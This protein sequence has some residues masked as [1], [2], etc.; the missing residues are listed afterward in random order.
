MISVFENLFIFY[1]FLVVGFFF[2]R[3][4]KGLQKQTGILSF[5]LC[6]L[7]LPCKLF[8]NFSKNFT[9]EYIASGYKLVLAG[10]VLIIV[11]HFLSKLITRFI[12]KDSY[13]KKVYEYSLTIS[14]Y[15]YLGYALVEG[16]F[17]ETMLTNMIA[18]C[19]FYAAYSYTVGYTKLTGEWS[20]KKLF[21]PMFV[22]I[23]LGMIVGLSG[24]KI[25]EFIRSVFS[26]ASSSVAPISMLL[27]GIALSVFPLK[28]I[29]KDKKSYV[30]VAIRLVLLPLLFF[31]LCKGLKVDFILPLCVI[32][33]ALPT[34]LN[35]IVFAEKFGKPT[36]YG[37]RLAFLSH[38]FSVVTLP[39]LMYLI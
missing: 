11:L 7:L 16:V 10:V 19:I 39:L 33:T 1:V 4:E 5:F 30:I 8:A 20:I 35:T 22:S 26:L 32:V 21:N 25:P 31:V 14:N 23:I 34:G 2:G 36:I 29:I 15:S 6:N 27:T 13:E 9:V 18:F 28:E 3:K 24:L 12:A 38:L 37:A 17:G